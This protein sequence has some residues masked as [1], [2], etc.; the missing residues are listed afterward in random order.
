MDTSTDTQPKPRARRPRTGSELVMSAA[1]VAALAG[2]SR[3]AIERA[4][5]DE[6]SPYYAAR[7]R[8]GIDALRFRRADVEAL[9]AGESAKV[10]TMRGRR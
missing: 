2:V 10:L 1:E 6:A 5:L 7:I 4:A 9:L 3:R 8:D